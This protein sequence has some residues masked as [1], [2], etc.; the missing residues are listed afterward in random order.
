MNLTGQTV[1][2]KPEAESDDPIATGVHDGEVLGPAIGQRLVETA[3]VGELG[4]AAAPQE[5]DA[6]ADLASF[7]SHL[8]HG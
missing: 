6:E 5:G 8:D 4:R 3:D 7:D 2:Q 1:T